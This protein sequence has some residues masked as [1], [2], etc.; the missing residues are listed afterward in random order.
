[1]EFQVTDRAMSTTGSKRTM[2]EHG[3]M[4]VKDCAISR[5][6][7]TEYA[8][9]NFQPRMYNDR[10]P[11]DVIRV[12]RSEATLAESVP[13][14]QGSPAAN[15]HPAEFFNTANIKKFQVG[16]VVGLPYM[17]GPL[18]KA[19]VLFTDPL[20]IADINAGKDE[21]S[22]GY[23]SGYDFTPGISP[24]G[25]VYD[26]EQLRLR[27]NHVAVVAAGR[28][29]SICRVSDSADS[30]TV[31]ENPSMGTVTVGGVTYEATEQLAQVIAGLQAQLSEL[32]AKVAGS[33]AEAEAAVVAAQGEAQ[34]AVAQVVGL[35]AQLA[36]ATDPAT[37]DAAVDERQEVLDHARKILPE[38]DHKGKTNDV[39]R[40]EVV[41]AK[42]PDVKNLDSADYVRARFDA[43]ATTPAAAPDSLT[44]ALR[45]SIKNTDSAA[46]ADFPNADKAR[47]A[48]IER[49]KQMHLPRSQRK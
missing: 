5:A 19:D 38:L 23:Y 45:Q 21:L 31:K 26:C 15:D 36:V 9:G 10:N 43:L 48:A 7:V 8:A 32:M 39:I 37:I 13:L 35:T 30:L 14:W 18:L 33:G 42:C 47:A 44:A 4:L 17:Q 1:M 11:N 29:G 2:T 40:K 20:T 25:E 49:R 41:A 6:G 34:A 12:Y 16:S 24:S 46:D 3:F 22:N 28:C 27:P